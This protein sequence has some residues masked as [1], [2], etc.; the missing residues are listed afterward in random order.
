MGS[1]DVTSG[2]ATFWLDADLDE[3]PRHPLER[4]LASR[5]DAAA[6][7]RRQYVE[8]DEAGLGPRADA[9]GGLLR[10]QV[11]RID[12]IESALRRAPRSARAAAEGAR[13]R[14]APWPR[15]TDGSQARR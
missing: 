9:L 1:H 6:R 14:P 3:D 8:A 12:S 11:D 13:E 7:Y 5:L 2:V 4:E 15:T 10:R